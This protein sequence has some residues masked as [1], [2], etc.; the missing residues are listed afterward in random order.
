MKKNLFLGMAALLGMSL[1]FTACS[2]DEDAVSSAANSKAIGFSVLTNNAAG[3]RAT[4]ITPDNSDT[5]MESIEVWGYFPDET[6]NQASPDK[7]YLGRPGREGVVFKNTNSNGIFDY[8]DPSDLHYWPTDGR[9]LNFYALYPT[10]NNGEHGFQTNTDFTL[11]YTIPTDQTKQVDLMFA[12]SE[13]QTMSTDADDEGKATLYFKHKLSQILFKAK[14]VSK[15]IEVEIKS[16]TIHNVID[17]GQ[18]DVTANENKIGQWERVTDGHGVVNTHYSNYMVG[19]KEPAEVTYYESDGTTI[20]KPVSA[21]DED[22]VLML[23]PQ[24]LAAKDKG[25]S[26]SDA[27]K[28]NQCYIEVEA[29]I[30]SIGHDETDERAAANVTYLLG[31]ETSYDKTYISLGTKWKEGTKYTYTLVFGDS[32]GAGET[33]GGAPTLTKIGFDV[34]VEDWTDYTWTKDSEP[35]NGEI[36]L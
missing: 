9:V 16:I 30:K 5:K 22:G 13:N 35:A 15:D 18:F 29:K 12:H 24:Q 7:Y 14:T 2:S 10:E 8:N 26:I 21:T 36:K 27:D 25:T 19:L 6:T 20:K 33:E 3:T 34:D 1:A 11:K 32:N 28:N 4:A 31:S 23:L 17:N